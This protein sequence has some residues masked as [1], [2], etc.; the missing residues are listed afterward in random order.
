MKINWGIALIIFFTIYIAL[1]VRIVVKSFQVDH[2]LVVE[3]YYDHDI[4]YQSKFD[5]ISNRNFLKEDLSILVEKHSNSL[6]LNFGSHAEVDE[7]KVLLY[8]PSDKH[9]DI[10]KTLTDIGQ[11]TTLSIANLSDGI[12]NVKVS[13]KDQNC[14]YYKEQ[15]IYW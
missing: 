7:A 11:T 8:R 1:L 3:N 13:W 12:W 5:D 4:H 9:Q 2:S 15:K 6:V 10:E 14:S